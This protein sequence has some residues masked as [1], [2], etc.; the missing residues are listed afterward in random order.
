MSI[1]IGALVVYHGS[2]R[3]FHGLVV[4]VGTDYRV[5]GRFILRTMEG[6]TLSHVRPESFYLTGLSVN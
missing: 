5:D 6:E 3:A 1:P 2:L 4:L